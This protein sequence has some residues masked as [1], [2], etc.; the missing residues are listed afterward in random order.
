M[1]ILHT[2][3]FYYPSIGGAQEV[4]RQLSERMAALGHDVTVVTTKLRERKINNIK[5]VKIKE[6]DIS[7]NQVNG[8]KG[9]A[10]SYKNYL[11][12]NKFDIIM[13]YA[14]QQ[15]TSDIFFE[16]MDK[17]QA[18]KVLVPCGFS[19]LK[20]PLYS[21][22]F[23]RM[24]NI[25]R[26]YDA[27]VYLSPK[28]QDTNFAKKNNLKNI[29]IIP[30]G[31]S[32]EEFKRKANKLIREKYKIKS[33]TFLITTIGSHTG[34][35][36]HHET[37][38][39]YKKAKINNSTLVLIGNSVN[40]GCIDDCVAKANKFN[41]SPYS[42]IRKNKILVLEISRKDTVDLLKSSDIFLF[43]S[44]IEASPLVLFESCAAKTPFLT[45][46]VGNSKEIIKFT[47]GGV[48][49]PTAID[50][51]GLSHV[52]IKKGSA[53]LRNLYSNEKE[54]EEMAMLGYSS[55]IHNY[56]WGKIVQNYLK[57]Y[58]RLITK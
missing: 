55:W 2:V 13:N 14:A 4:V 25:L 18:K 53:A 7:G 57:L 30:N 10:E 54:R 51:S 29:E 46:D 3:E 41:I 24:P 5:G 27:T 52:D 38:E 31:A 47:G 48:L 35:K 23:S 37:I 11:L 40:G 44:N 17:I 6:F 21:A 36:G 49:L 8:Y 26:R 50:N 33:D 19:G 43:C 45:A 16:V 15:W 34:Q 32:E 28:Y 12:N 9:E 1:K 58:K 22:Y 42:I 20:N 39:L 56:T